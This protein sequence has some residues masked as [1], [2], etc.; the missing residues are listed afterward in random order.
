MWASTMKLQVPFVQLPIMFD[1][2]RMA[3]EIAAMDPKFWRGRTSRDDGN[4][5]LTLITT[6]GDPDS[7]ALSGPMRPTPALLQSPYIMQVLAETGATWGRTRLMRLSVNAEVARHIDIHYYWRERMRVHFPVVTAPQVRFQC[8]NAEINMKAGECWIFDT[9]RRHRVVNEGG[10]QRI[11]LVA[12]T[13][14]GE[15]FWQHMAKGR[16]PGAGGGAWMPQ[17]VAPTQGTAPPLDYESVNMPVVMTPW[18]IRTHASFLVSEAVPDPR[19]GMVRQLLFAFARDWQAAWACHGESREGWPRYRR[20]LDLAFEALL[21]AGADKLGLHNEANLMETLKAHIF[22]VALADRASENTA[23]DVHG[24]AASTQQLMPSVPAVQAASAEDVFDRPIF[25]VS[26]PRSGST[27]LFETLSRA[28]GLFTIG[29]ESHR[30][31]EGVAGLNPAGR[32][33][34]SNRLLAADADFETAEVLR[35]R[36]LGQL[37]DREGQRPAQGQRI[38]ML[39]K[40]PKNALRIPFLTAVFPQARFVYLHRDPR[41]V[42]ASMREGWQSGNFRMYSDLPGWSGEPWSFLLVPGWRDLVGRPVEEIVA[43]QWRRTMQ[44]MRDDLAQLPEDAWTTVD[45]DRFVRDPQA[46][47]GKLCAWADLAWDQ[48][49]DAGLPLSRYTLTAP[50]AEKWRRHEH[51]VIPALERIGAL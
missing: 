50:H 3:D 29:D 22:D 17:Y 4:S 7:D 36:F 11:H 16:P 2:Q 28:P 39:E 32:G 49:L 1:V 48:S 8:G 12:D 5:A 10:A 20:L 26:P 41:E 27:L 33:Y 25:I 19:L 35:R 42:L 24:V 30:L 45:Y 31:I 46:E 9:W 34:D 23:Q 6:D 51:W 13:V 18:E 43:E 15:R 44:I 47:I 21:R 38:R 40:T 37:R 14:G